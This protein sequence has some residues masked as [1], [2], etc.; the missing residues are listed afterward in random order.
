KSDPRFREF[1]PWHYVNIEP[2]KKYGDE[3]P[4]KRGDIVS[5]IQKCITVVQ[6]E[7]ASKEDRAFF[8]KL[9]VHF[10][11]D[12]H[13]P[14]HVGYPKDRG[15]ND[16]QLRWFNKGT[17]LHRLWDT[18]M[19]EFYDMSFTE[20]SENLPVLDKKEK[21]RITQGELLDWVADSQLVAK[22]VYQSV[23]V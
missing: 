4:S 11:G 14:M 15:G 12:L 8:L 6:D 9:L 5:G 23:E 21:E 10:I 19:I 1:G 22:Q 13:Q 20:L 2:G 7:N 3:T 16:I 17:N 18:D